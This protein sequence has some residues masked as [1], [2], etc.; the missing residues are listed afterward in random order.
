MKLGKVLAVL[1]AVMMAVGVWGVSAQDDALLIWADGARAPLLEELGAEFT[2]DYDIEVIVHEVG[3]GD[4]RDQMKTAG[5]AGEGP[6]LMV[7]A[8]DWLGNLAVNGLLAEIDLAD[9]ADDYLPAALQAF[10]YDGVQYGLPY[11]SENVAFIRNVDLVPENPA[12]WDEVRAISEQLMAEGKVQYGYVIQDNDPYHSFP[13]VT[14][15]GGYVFG[16]T[17]EGYDPSDVGIDSEGAIASAIFLEELVADG[18]MPSGVDYEVMHTLFETGEVAMIIT[19]PWASA[20]S[21]PDN[22]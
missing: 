20:D 22:R 5:P 3:F 16:L 7:G 14:A 13:I 11:A 17:D 15:F 21:L 12:T 9:I 19:G 2:A 18:L 4:V 1:M 6:D 8:H 10:V